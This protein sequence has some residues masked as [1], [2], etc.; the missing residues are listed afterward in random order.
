MQAQMSS[1]HQSKIKLNYGQ[2]IKLDYALINP[3]SIH[4]FGYSDSD[5]L[6]SN[7]SLKWLAADMP[8]SAVIQYR[9]VSIKL[10]YRKKDDKLIQQVYRE[11]P[12]NYVPEADRQNTGYSQLNT[13]GNI[14]RGIGFGNA[15]DIVVNSNLNLRIN[16]LLPNGVEV[17]AAI[18]DENNPIQPE[19]NTQQIQDFDQVYITLKK[20]STSLTVGDFLMQRPNESY[21]VN[22]YKK[23]RGLQLSTIR[24]HEKYSSRVQAEAAISRG[25]FSRNQIDGIDGNSGPYRLSGS[26]GEIF[27]IVIAGTE[28]LY[29]DGK[30]LE[31]GEDND[32]VIN[33]NTGEITFTPKI[34]ITRYSR[35]VVEF[36]YSDRNYARSVF[37]TGA[38]VQIN[39]WNV[40]A[41]FFNEMDLKN[42][43]FQQDL[44]G[45]DSVA[46]ISALELLNQ[47]GDN[48][49]IFPNTRKLNSF[50]PDRIM[51]RKIDSLGTE[52]YVYTGDP[53]SDSIFYE[54]NFTNLGIGKGSYV[55][56]QSAANGKVFEY[57]GPALGDYEPVE[58][59]IAPKRLNMWNI[60]FQ[61]AHKYGT[62]GLELSVSDL[63]LN[64]FSDVGDSD[65]K[66]YGLKA[67][68][69]SKKLVFD[70]AYTFSHHLDYEM[71]SNG[72]N[73]VERYRPVEFNRQWNKIVNNPDIL[74]TLISTYEHIANA[75]A[76]LIKNEK[77]FAKLS[78]SA[79]IKPG[80]FDGY[81]L[82]TA[83]GYGWKHTKL[84]AGI[85]LLQ[86]SDKQ[87]SIAV[88]NE[89]YHLNALLEQDI[90]KSIAGFKIASESSL[91]SLS[92]S[93][94]LKPNSYN[95]KQLELYF[96]DNGAQK[97]RYQLSYVQR[98][99]ERLINEGLGLA[100]IG[101][102][103]GGSIV[104][105]TE[106][107][108]RIAIQ[109][110][111]RNIEVLDSQFVTGAPDR[112]LQS[113][114]ELDLSLIK[115]LIKTKSFFQVGTGQE[116]KR[117]FQ[118]LQVQTGNGVYI[119][120]DYDSNGVKTLDEFEVASDF[121]KSRADYI[122]IYTPVP[123][124]ITTRMTKLSETLEINPAAFLRKTGGKANFISR[125]YS[126][127]SLQYEQKTLPQNNRLVE[128]L[129]NNINDSSLI[130]KSSSFRSSIFYN[131]SNPKFGMDY[132]YITNQ[133]KVL[134]TNGFDGRNSIENKF[135]VRLNIKR[136]WTLRTALI[137]GNKLYTSEFF[138]AR[139]FHYYFYEVQPKMQLQLSNTFRFELKGAYYSAYNDSLYGGETSNKIELGT[140]VKFTK[141]SQS[142]L[143]L[144]FSYVKVD[145]KGETGTAL[146][147]ELLRGLQDGNNATWNVS[148]QQ[149]LAGNIQL[150]ISYD[151]R[152]SEQTPVIHIGRL[153]A[154][155]LF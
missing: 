92:D 60:G 97:L 1:L 65:N 133:S 139:N 61:R 76:Q 5:Y 124:F 46:G 31:R 33:Y 126:L 74:S 71:V 49:A 69:K 40:Y 153:V 58:V 42:Q 16:G 99:D 104:Y 143:Q 122:K 52:I 34:L 148:Y 101:K 68:K 90:F 36:Q 77:S 134:L 19:G 145:Y 82:K 129:N 80:V 87:D 45:Y 6:F 25:R 24:H 15:Q 111:Y 72:F 155:Y 150:L 86:S 142:S 112:S 70:S 147:Y 54:L 56:I 17:L 10:M 114:I 127:S 94:R 35:I 64:T 13:S 22:Y 132:S 136:K 106:N 115:Q 30:L 118:Y 63:D 21:F 8:D 62:S 51:Y 79:F 119:W 138:E 44:D 43:P 4:I 123:G 2:S 140:G 29:L 105:Q 95:F 81:N 135:N 84:G 141:A 3:T 26:N 128:I 50:N 47:A 32:Y 39:K 78:A 100:T 152:K 27:I 131:R 146:G 108:N 107:Y 28:K 14:S 110:T 20:D 48:N 102:D 103:I 12:F 151:G 7:D 91:F 67:F 93:N 11:N 75:E 9:T 55:Q 41:N 85:D 38:G 66:G 117:E 89:F 130:N 125:F 154:R 53:K 144:D 116:Q 137:R 37:H 73:Y 88:L 113:R 120:N 83:M 98:N 121:D 57:R 109:S 18:S 96:K 59:L 23:S 149:R